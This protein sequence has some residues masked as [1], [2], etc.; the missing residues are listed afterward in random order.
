MR[1][2][3]SLSSA[4]LLLA[5]LAVSLLPGLASCSSSTAAS[6]GAGVL[7]GGVPGEYSFGGVVVATDGVKPIFTRV[8]VSGLVPVRTLSWN[9]PLRD[10]RTVYLS[11]YADCSGSREPSV[12]RLGGGD[13]IVYRVVLPASCEA[14]GHPLAWLFEGSASIARQ[15]AGYLVRVNITVLRPLFASRLPEGWRGNY[16][17]NLTIPLE[18]PRRLEY[19]IYVDASTGAS[20]LV[21]ANGRPV[22]VELGFNPFYE[23]VLSNASAFRRV[24]H[25]DREA[26]MRYL[27]STVRIEAVTGPASHVMG[28][29]VYYMSNL[30]Y[31]VARY[32]RRLLLPVRVRATFYFHHN[33]SIYSYIPTAGSPTTLDRVERLLSML[34][35]DTARPGHGFPSSI[36]AEY[37]PLRPPS[38]VVGLNGHPQP[39]VTW[40][41]CYSCGLPVIGGGFYI[42]GSECVAVNFILPHPSNSSVIL[43]FNG[44]SVRHAGGFDVEPY[45]EYRMGRLS[46]IPLG[47]TAL[48]VLA[49]SAALLAFLL[50]RRGGLVWR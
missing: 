47:R 40:I 18:M 42:S 16:T 2:A 33:R 1:L 6:G 11:L 3:R 14:L 29:R 23:P 25:G 36:L 10:G 34:A 20:R 9:I 37:T 12:E 46:L 28:F 15:G 4:A 44:A 43:F 27:N 13:T 26:V 17:L 50:A 39:G 21:E 48:A 30:E 24:S 8:S 45:C 32:Y 38:P 35:N 19:S 41:G 31:Q 49:A 22:E 5:L 7:P